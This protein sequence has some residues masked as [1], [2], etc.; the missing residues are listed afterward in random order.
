MEIQ[1]S[2]LHYREY[3]SYTNRR[4]IRKYLATT[5]PDVLTYFFKLSKFNFRN[6]IKTLILVHM[7][8]GRITLVFYFETPGNFE[9]YLHISQISLEIKQEKVISI[10]ALRFYRKT[11]YDMHT[12][13]F[14]FTFSKVLTI[15][16]F[17]EQRV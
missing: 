10:D 1:M 17:C 14:L 8:S 11:F 9:Y 5:D 2:L 13:I 15:F 6:W 7:R 12:F 16:H 4:V 3:I